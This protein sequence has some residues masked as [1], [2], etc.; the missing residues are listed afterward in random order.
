MRDK[1]YETESRIQAGLGRISWQTLNIKEFC[2]SCEK[3]LKS[4]S[5]IVVQI[6]IMGSDIRAKVNKLESYSLFEM[7]ADPPK[8]WSAD[9]KPLPV[10]LKTSKLGKISETPENDLGDTA[11][12]TK[13]RKKTIRINDRDESVMPCVEYFKSL[14]TERNHKTNEIQRLYDSIGPIMI[15]LE[16]LII[17]TFTGESD[18][19]SFYYT[20]WEKEMFSSLTR[21]TTRSLQ[22]FGEKLM[23][24][25]VMFEVDAVLAAPEIIMKPSFNEIYNIMVHSVKDFLER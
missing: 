22:E 1:L 14:E 20:H 2:E 5:A 23:R 15:K 9:E 21:F 6:G 18:K 3:L 11:T 17:G 7:S 25:E 19:M 24:N 10:I 4:L 16:S 12:A 8:G 13:P